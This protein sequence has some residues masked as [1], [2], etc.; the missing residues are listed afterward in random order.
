[1]AAGSVALR[2]LAGEIRNVPFKAMLPVVKNVK[3]YAG[4]QGGRMTNVSKRGVKLRAVDRQWPGKAENV[5]VW[6]IQGVPVGPWV[7]ATY[8]TAAH[9]IRR[10]KRGKKRKMLVHHPGGSGRGSW[11]RVVAYAERI[12]PAVF[13]DELERVLR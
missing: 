11:A 7:W 9:D 2:D 12:V 8:G 1:M 5:V 3:A 13:T 10:R 4:Q 6:R